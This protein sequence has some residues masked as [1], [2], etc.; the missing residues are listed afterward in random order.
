MKKSIRTILNL[1]LV[2]VFLFSTGRFLGQQRDN[3]AGKDAYSTALALASSGNSETPPPQTKTA[4]NPQTELQWVAAPPEGEDPYIRQLEEISLDALRE[5]NPQV[6]GWILIPDTEISYPL[7]QGTDNDYYLKRTWDGKRND[8]GSIFLEHLSSSDL[9]DFHTIIYG[10]N[11]KNGSM[12]AG[13]QNYREESY[14][15]EHP[16]VYIRSDDGV[17]RYEIFSSYLAKVDST[18]YGLAFPDEEAKALFLGNAI[19]D[20]VIQ[21][22]VEVA[23]TDRI[24]TLSTCSGK[25]Y[26][27]RWVV[28]A[29]L[30]MIQAQA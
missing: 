6:V 3:A 13:L 8:V 17:F 19:Q 2:L 28:H 29:R 14:R 26:A 30:K 24:L 21:T 9:T 7:M 20:S 10:H 18:T 4:E 27:T 16:Y 25:G 15:E 1:L 11:M 23:A 12:F 5:V 22:D